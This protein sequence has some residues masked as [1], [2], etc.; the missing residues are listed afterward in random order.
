MITNH[1]EK[2]ISE[3]ENCEDPALSLHLAVLAIFT[4]LTQNMLHASGRLVPV[5][6]A[7]LKT[8][9]KEEYLNHLQQYHGMT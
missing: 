2:L 6:I 9:L 3:L 1:R 4:I 7:Y 8:Q 5:I